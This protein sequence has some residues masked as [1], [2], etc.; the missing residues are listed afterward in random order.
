[1]KKRLK[2]KV[3]TLHSTHTH[4]HTL[5]HIRTITFVRLLGALAAKKKVRVMREMSVSVWCGVSRRSKW[6]SVTTRKREEMSQEALFGDDSVEPAE[7]RH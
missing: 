6:R 5:L 1:M 4:T 3:S 2:V 7:Q